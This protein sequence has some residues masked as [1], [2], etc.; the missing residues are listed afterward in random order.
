MI[1]IA[2][3]EYS[4]IS[5]YE[6]M[7]IRDAKSLNK[8]YAKINRTRKPGLPVPTLDFSKEIVLVVCLGEQKGKKLLT[9]SSNEETENEVSVSIEMVDSDEVEKDK[10]Q[11]VS[12]PFYIYKIPHTS[13][14]I[15][16]EK[17]GW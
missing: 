13:K 16:F 2:H 10:V 14:T 4:G 7:V 8:F 3:D 5:E 11:Y 9:L 17:I 15:N 1:L 6:T 12:Y